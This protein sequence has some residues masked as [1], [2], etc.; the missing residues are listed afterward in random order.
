[1]KRSDF[2]KKLGSGI[3]VTAFLPAFTFCDSN[4]RTILPEG[5]YN[6]NPGFSPDVDVELKAIQC[7]R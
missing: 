2:M 6:I 1:M 4:S 7:T 5:N 3:A